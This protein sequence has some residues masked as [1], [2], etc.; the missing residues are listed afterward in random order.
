MLAEL[1]L[2]LSDVVLPAAV[3]YHLGG[4]SVARLNSPS[5]PYA[6]GRAVGHVCGSLARKTRAMIASVLN[7]TFQVDAS[8]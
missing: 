8:Q 1:F 4:A 5:D 6:S 2:L 7:T 3:V